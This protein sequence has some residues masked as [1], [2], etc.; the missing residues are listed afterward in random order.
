MWCGFCRPNISVAASFVWRCLSGQPWLRAFPFGWCFHF[1]RRRMALLGR[2]HPWAY[3]GL[4]LGAPTVP[5][6]TMAPVSGALES[7]QGDVLR[8]ISRRT[9][10][11][12]EGHLRLRRR[13]TEQARCA[14]INP[15]LLTASVV[16][17]GHG[18]G[19]SVSSR[20]ESIL[21]RRPTSRAIR[22]QLKNVAPSSRI[23]LPRLRGVYIGPDLILGLWA[24]RIRDH[25]PEMV[26]RPARD[27]AQGHQ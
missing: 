5:T 16:G 10:N 24:A 22:L 20:A 9:P 23:S 12:D 14:I 27:I 25:R 21:A 18:E 26:A 6:I 3:F 13:L 11:A 2:S 7:H 17:P 15:G 8:A 4:S 19:L 1:G